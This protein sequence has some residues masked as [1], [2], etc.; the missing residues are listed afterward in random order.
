MTDLVTRLREAIDETERVAR[1]A[2]A[3]WSLEGDRDELL[4]DFG[5]HTTSAI[6]WYEDDALRPA[7]ARHIV[8]QNPQV[9]LRRCAADRKILDW[10]EAVDEYR[11]DHTLWN[12]PEADEPLRALAEYYEVEV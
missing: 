2:G 7:E 3:R 4:L 9:T 10:I 6:G 11:I 8:R 5:G 1:E 12:A